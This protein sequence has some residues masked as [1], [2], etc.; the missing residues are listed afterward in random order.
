MPKNVGDLGTLIV[1]KGFERLPKITQ[2]GHTGHLALKFAKF[3]AYRQ[4]ES[5]L[6]SGRD[7]QDLFSLKDCLRISFSIVVLLSVPIDATQL[8]PRTLFHE[9]PFVKLH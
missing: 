7:V 9:K 4:G 1:A 8:L 6:S 2:S 3:S 5:K